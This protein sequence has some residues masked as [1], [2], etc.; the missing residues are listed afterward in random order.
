MEDLRLHTGWQGRKRAGTVVPAH[1]HPHCELVCYLSGSGTTVIGGETHTFTAGTF[2][3]IPPEVVHDETHRADG[4]VLCL[5]FDWD[6][7]AAVTV[8]ADTDGTVF[9]LAM[10]MLEEATLQRSGYREM[11]RAGLL[12]LRVTLERMRGDVSGPKNFE[13][14]ANVLRENY[15]DRIVLSRLAAQMNLSY[16]YFQHRFR[17]CLGLSPQQYLLRCRLDAAKARLAGT[18]DSCTEIAYRCGFSNCSQFS[19][20]FRRETGMTPLQYRKDVGH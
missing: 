19:M 15:Y 16:D 13:Y 12:E 14:V 18:E 17:Q 9:R 6:R 5:G 20:L 11:L 4:A 10:S 7:P 3:L 2:A 1:S 8:A